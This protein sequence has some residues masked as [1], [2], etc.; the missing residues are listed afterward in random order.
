MGIVTNDDRSEWFLRVGS[1]T[2]YGLASFFITVVNKTVLTSYAFPSFQVLA[3]GQMFATVVVLFIARNLGILT[4]PS[5]DMSVLRKIW[6][7]P[8]IFVGNV[9][10]GWEP[11]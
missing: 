10:S 9:V 3:L 7:L 8:L 5:P 1:A 2:F 6:P 11:V 4:F